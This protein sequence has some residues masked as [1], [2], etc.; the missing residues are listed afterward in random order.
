DVAAG[1]RRRESEHAAAQGPAP[2][3]PLGGGAVAVA[4]AVAG[5][6]ERS[7]VGQRP[8]EE[9]FLGSLAYLFLSN[10]SVIVK[11]PT[12]N[13]SRSAVRVPANWLVSASTFSLL[14]PRSIVCRRKA[15]WMRA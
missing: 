14:P 6:V 8:V 15:R 2:L 3:I 12:V 5:V 13:T 1:G 7:G 4:P 11:R 9:S 10:M